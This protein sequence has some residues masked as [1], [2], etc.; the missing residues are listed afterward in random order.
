ILKIWPSKLSSMDLDTE[1]HAL[2]L[3]TPHPA[4][5]RRKDALEVYRTIWNEFYYSWEKDYCRIVIQTCGRPAESDP[6][7]E[8]D[9]NLDE[10]APL[11]LILDTDDAELEYFTV[12][13]FDAFENSECYSTWFCSDVD[14]SRIHGHPRY[15]SSSIGSHSYIAPDLCTHPLPFIPFSDDVNFGVED[16]GNM[17]EQFA[18]Q[19]D[20]PDPDCE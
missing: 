5:S 15:Q 17:F 2:D 14:D 1:F 16:H 7:S 8:S 3:G 19:T 20:F 10:S 9:I 11:E 4:E 12:E 18:W 6:A 13:Q